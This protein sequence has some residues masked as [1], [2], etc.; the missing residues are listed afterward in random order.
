MMSRQQFDDYQREQLRLSLFGAAD[1]EEQFHRAWERR[2]PRVLGMVKRELVIR[3][4]YIAPGRLERYEQRAELVE[5]GGVKVWYA[6]D[7]DRAIEDL[8]P[9]AEARADA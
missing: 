3:D 4:V 7:V 5:I 1:D 8:G 9:R 6:S 2:Y